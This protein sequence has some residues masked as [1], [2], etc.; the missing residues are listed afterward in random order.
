MS[1]ENELLGFWRRRLKDQERHLVVVVGLAGLFVLHES[2]Q[3]FRIQRSMVLDLAERW[4]ARSYEMPNGDV[5]VTV[6]R[7]NRGD[8]DELVSELFDWILKDAQLSDEA[9]RKRVD[10]FSLPEQIHEFR[11]AIAR[12]LDSRDA[13]G[14]ASGLVR[15]DPDGAGD[16]V[17]KGPLVPAM[18]DRLERRIMRSDIRP[19]V[20]R[21]AIYE[22]PASP[23]GR[24]LPLVEER[25]ISLA[26]LR[27]RM[28]PQVEIASTNPL[29]TQVCRFLDERMLHHLMARRSRPES[30]VSFNISVHTVI[31]RVFDT[32]LAQ[33]PE[34]NRQNL[35]VEIHCGEL[36][37]DVTKSLA[38]IQRLRGH[39]LGVIIDGITL[40][41]LPYVRI[42]K[43]DH[44]Y[45]KLMLP[46]GTVPLLESGSR[47]R[48]VRKLPLERV[49]LSQCDHEAAIRIGDALGIRLYQGWHLDQYH[50]SPKA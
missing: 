12:Y 5:V 6:A 48:A 43:I 17:L 14:P 32:F 35:M 2:S 9:I 23:D 3:Q 50:A 19:F 8:A 45:L 44:D 10:M 34:V 15:P 30:K 46:R 7:N 31:D 18:L 22:K 40:E 16:A 24:W 42:D 11:Q 26:R 47:I 39:G 25:R 1:A 29:F 13:E 37:Q 27:E 20:E 49:I 4:G 36:F 21:Q 28:F 41:F 33:I 38:A